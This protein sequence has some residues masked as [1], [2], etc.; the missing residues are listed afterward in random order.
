MGTLDP[1]RRAQP[2]GTGGTLMGVVNKLAAAIAALGLVGAV[3]APAQA[4][5]HRV[6]ATGEEDAN[7]RVTFKVVVKKGE[8]V[9]VK[10]VK[11]SGLDY[12]CEDWQTAGEVSIKL[13]R[14]FKV[15]SVGTVAKSSVQN[16]HDYFLKIYFDNDKG[17]KGRGYWTSEFMSGPLGCFTSW[18]DKPVSSY[19]EFG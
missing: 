2:G 8:A 18:E 15:D 12:L 5:G 13:K 4:A 14:T 6:R 7:L 3:A 9:K 11:I 17:S 1:S 10:N 19:F 16:G